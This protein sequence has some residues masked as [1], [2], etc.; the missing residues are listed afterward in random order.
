MGMLEIK[1]ETRS[2]FSFLAILL[3]AIPYLTSIYMFMGTIQDRIQFI[4]QER[5]GLVYYQTLTDLRRKVQKERSE[6]YLLASPQALVSARKAVHGAI[7]QIDAKEA[8][9][10]ALNVTQEWSELK[11]HIL[12]LNTHTK[13]NQ[14]R[15][16]TLKK[17]TA[18]L[19]QID[20][21]S[22]VVVDNSNLVLDPQLDSYYLMDISTRSIPLLDEMIS[23]AHIAIWHRKRS[24]KRQG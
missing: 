3:F 23:R 21:F 18:V 9:V 22:R 17:Y 20:A 1:R 19:A 7:E 12:G 4:E 16:E 13:G 5:R 8:L 2:N 15:Q 14:S 6:A 24:W 10:V 11:Q